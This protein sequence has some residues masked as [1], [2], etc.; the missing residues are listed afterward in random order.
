MKV[1]IFT[2]FSLLAFSVNAQQN[3]IF[4]KRYVECEDKWVTFSMNEDSS[5]SYGF[6]YIDSDAV[7][8]FHEEGSF[9]FITPNKIENKKLGST[10]L[11]IRLEP[12]D[13]QVAIIPETMY[14]D[15][16]ISEVP[17]WLN[18]YKKD[19]NTFERNFKW[20]YMYNEWNE[21][22]KG[23][24]FLLKAKEINPNF[25]GLAAEIA[26]SYNC[27]KEY[28]NAVTILE[29]HIKKNP[30]NDYVIKEYIYSLTKTNGIDRAV[31]QYYTSTKS[32]NENIYNAENC[33]NILQYYYKHNDKNN[34][35]IFYTELHKY[36]D[37]SDE[38]KEYAETMK[39]KL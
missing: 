36:P 16:Q 2:I 10:S 24:S 35:K 29:E 26:F 37:A 19:V 6:I 38:L 22:R 4:N 25:E 33:F 32:V 13:N 5:Y 17:S 1:I 20:G 31:E 39:N 27:L 14:K 3:L 30:I 23:L 34:F 21:C 11:K 12:N 28:D 15:L 7:L 8:T 18:S 9:K